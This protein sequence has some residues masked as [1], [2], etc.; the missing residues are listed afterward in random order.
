MIERRRVAVPGLL[1]LADMLRLM[2]RLGAVQVRHS[3]VIVASVTGITTGQHCVELHYR[4]ADASLVEQA[5]AAWD[6]DL[7]AA[8]GSRTAAPGGG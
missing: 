5:I 3:D 2:G 4:K 8:H 1:T 7:V 6:L